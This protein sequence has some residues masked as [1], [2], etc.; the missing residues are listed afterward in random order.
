MPTGLKSL[1]K[2]QN[3]LEKFSDYEDIRM[4]REKDVTTLKCETDV[5]GG[6]L[7]TEGCFDNRTGLLNSCRNF[8]VYE[9]VNF[10]IVESTRAEYNIPIVKEDILHIP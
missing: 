6:I 4:E 1:V 8:Y 9:G 7:V 10:P 5:E 2:I 3:V